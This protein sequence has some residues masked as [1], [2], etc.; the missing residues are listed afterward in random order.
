MRTYIYFDAN[1]ANEYYRG[2]ILIL[3]KSKEIVTCVI[4]LCTSI[5]QF[6]IHINELS[7]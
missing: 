7:C 2:T 5:N 1:I 6:T 3:T 4:F